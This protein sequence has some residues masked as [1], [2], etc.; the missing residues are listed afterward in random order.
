MPPK[1]FQIER[2]VTH[3][4]GKSFIDAGAD[5]HVLDSTDTYEMNGPVDFQ[6]ATMTQIKKHPFPKANLKFIQDI[7]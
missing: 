4:L 6:W 7:T 5:S 1:R 3:I 2:S